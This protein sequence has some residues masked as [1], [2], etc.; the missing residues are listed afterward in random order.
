VN[1]NNSS[2]D[3]VC[4]FRTTRWSA[5]LLSA[6]S[7][8]PGSRAALAELCKLYWYPLYAFVRRRGYNG[9][10]AQDLTQ[11]FFL[12]LFDRKAL[13]QVTPLKGK[14]RSF[15][16]ASMKNYLSNE[17]DR[18]N[19][20][21]RGGSVKFV[22]LDFETGED[23]YQSEPH[24]ALTAEKIFDARWALTL[25]D[26][27][28]RLLREEYIVHRKSAVIET[29]EPFLDPGGSRELPSHQAIAE[30]LHVNPGGVKVLIH[31]LRKRYGELLRAEVARTVTNPEAVDEEIHALCEAVIATEG[32]IAP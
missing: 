5:V 12:S 15:L 21:K 31:R 18:R 29:L 7:Q 8:A 4:R 23:R 24:E 10:D 17:F 3:D 6:Q 19:S 14:F 11:G 26:E 25:L 28:L 27:A 9:E 30:K 22:P 2:G 16:L 32:R 20:L 1:P 13:R